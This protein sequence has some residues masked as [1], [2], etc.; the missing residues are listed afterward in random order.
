MSSALAVVVVCDRSVTRHVALNVPS[1]S[2]L[3]RHIADPGSLV[4]NSRDTNIFVLL[5]QIFLTFDTNIFDFDTKFLTFDTNIFDFD[6][7]I[8]YL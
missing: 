6:T 5:T 4:E 2:Q 3:F 7:N 1:Y 8:F